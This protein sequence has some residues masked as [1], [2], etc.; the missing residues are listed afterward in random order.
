MVK[1]P[2]SQKIWV[3]IDIFRVLQVYDESVELLDD[4]AEEAINDL[5]EAA[6]NTIMVLGM[7]T[8]IQ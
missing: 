5:A 2:R 8:G 4:D 6:L 7:P 3:V 1:S